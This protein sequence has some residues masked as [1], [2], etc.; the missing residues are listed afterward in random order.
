MLIL[1]LHRRLV[2][3]RINSWQGRISDEAA[4]NSLRVYEFMFLAFLN[5]IICIALSLAS[6]SLGV[7]VMALTFGVLTFVLSGVCVV[8]AWHFGKAAGIAIARGYGL[9]DRSWR[10][11]KFKTPEQFDKW[12]ALRGTT[13]QQPHSS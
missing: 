11:M 1:R 3:Q 13:T 8:F 2:S 12:L 4:D 6:S 5:A 10:K 7:P 9:P